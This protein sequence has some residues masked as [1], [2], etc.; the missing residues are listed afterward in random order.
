M[1][2]PG[3]HVDHHGDHHLR[4]V[5]ADQRQRAVEIE[6]HGLELATGKVGTQNLNGGIGHI[7][8]TGERGAK[9]YKASGGRYP[10]GLGLWQTS[11]DRSQYSEAGSSA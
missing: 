9:N 3:Q 4:P 6:Q 7:L 1:K 11:V 5:A 8:S 10:P 2:K